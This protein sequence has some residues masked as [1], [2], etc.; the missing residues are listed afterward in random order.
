MLKNSQFILVALLCLVVSQFNYAATAHTLDELLEQVKQAQTDATNTNRQRE[1]DF[2][3]RKQAQQQ[4]LQQSKQQLTRTTE[5]SVKLEKLY[6][7]NEEL[8]A[9]KQQQLAQRLG[10]LQE[11][12]GHIMASANDA[13]AS[14]KHSIISGQY[15]QRGVFLE[16]LL[17]KMRSKTEIPQLDE[18]EGLWFELH[19][20]LTASSQITNFSAPVV[21]SD[22]SEKIQ[23]VLRV[24]SFN[25]FAAGD[26]LTYRPDTQTIAELAKQ[27][28]KFLLQPNAYSAAA[29]ELQT[30]K[31]GF[32][33]VAIDP[34]GGNGG[35]FL[36]AMVHS[37]S[38]LERWHQGQ[39]V[40]YIISL[41]GVISLIIAGWRLL[42]LRKIGKAIKLDN[43]LSSDNPVAAL[44]EAYNHSQNLT[45]ETIELKLDEV[46]LVQARKIN[47]ASN[48]LKFIAMVAPLLGLLGTV[49]GMIITFQALTIFG[50]NDTQ[51]MAGG[52]SNA[53]VT[54]VLGLVVALP[55]LLLHAIVTGRA[56]TILQLLQEK[57]IALMAQHQLRKS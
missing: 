16:Q 14:F 55:S 54:T 56:K 30:A 34:T 28:V 5:R 47:L 24:G 6:A 33:S 23:Q 3:Q 12:F 39:I 44:S 27:P 52:I 45:L 29:M 31:Q 17:E 25:L 40:G 4:L 42:V 36:A 38:L 19:R 32:T 46:L 21:A 37:P 2:V 43:K 8:V 13:K 11:V 26:Y 9:A 57:S 20:E 1:Q 15:P 50:S 10:V 48:W 22:G 18:I 7:K 51:A 49:A 41:L 35:S 53:L